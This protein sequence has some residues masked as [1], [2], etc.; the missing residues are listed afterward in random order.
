MLNYQRVTVNLTI[1]NGALLA[2]VPV[3]LSFDGAYNFTGD[4]RGDFL[5]GEET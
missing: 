5:Q 4:I 1:K 3:L 2:Y